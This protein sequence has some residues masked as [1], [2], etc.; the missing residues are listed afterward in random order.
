MI[1][2]TAWWGDCIEIRIRS[3]I[4]FKESSEMVYFLTMYQSNDQSVSYI[5]SHDFFFYARGAVVVL[6]YVY[7]ANTNS[8]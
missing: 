6:L 3:F 8:V 1:L 5:L 7:V 2:S 4:N